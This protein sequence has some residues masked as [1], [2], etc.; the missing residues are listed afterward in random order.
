MLGE[1]VI[2][3]FAFAPA[4]VVFWISVALVVPPV[5]PPCCYWVSV[6]LRALKRRK[7][8]P[9]IHKVV[10]L[11][12][13]LTRFLPLPVLLSKRILPTRHLWSISVAAIPF[14]RLSPSLQPVV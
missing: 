13:R 9:T 3:L 8:L 10:G 14:S 11:Q 12:L 6:F 1:N 5:F 4:L 2:A 7:R